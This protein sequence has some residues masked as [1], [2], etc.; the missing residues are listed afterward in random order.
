MSPAKFRWGLIL[1]QIGVI[2]LLFNLDVIGNRAI[3]DL[4]VLFPVVLIAVGIEKLFTK[5]KLSFI[6]Y[7]SSI[8]LFLGGLAVVLT[9]QGSS[10]YDDFFSESTFSLEADPSIERI[11][12]TLKLDNANLKIRDAGQDLIYARFDKFTR[13]PKITHDILDGISNIKFNSRS[14]SFLGGAVQVTTDEP[15]DWYI[16]FSEE[17]PLE[18]ECVGEES[19]IHLNLSTSLLEKLNIDADKSEIYVKLGDLVPEVN[20]TIAGNDSDLKLRLPETAGVRISGE[21]ISNYLDALGFVESDDGSYVNE[22]YDTFET[23]INVEIKSRI[24]NFIVDMY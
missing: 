22:D 19:Y 15:Q 3:E 4:L 21:D 14:G 23:R 24:N 7:L 1:I 2:I 17:I 6:A 20:V 12:A 11:D 18:L 16:R 5:T 13:K 9:S 10:Y 8:F